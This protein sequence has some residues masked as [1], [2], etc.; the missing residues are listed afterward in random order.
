MACYCF[1][2]GY[3]WADD[4]R[5]KQSA[6]YAAL[7]GSK[8]KAPVPLA[9]YLVETG[10]GRLLTVCQWPEELMPDIERKGGVWGK[11]SVFRKWATEA[12]TEV[13]QDADIL[14]PR[15]EGVET[16]AGGAR[17]LSSFRTAEQAATTVTPVGREAIPS[18]PS[19]ERYLICY[20]CQERN[21]PDR[22]ACAKCGADLL[23]AR[24][25]VERIG[26]LVGGAI[27]AAGF[28]GLAYALSHVEDPL[29]CASPPTLLVMALAALVGGLRMGFGKTPEYEKYE[30]RAQRQLND[31]PQQALADLTKALELAPEK[32]KAGILKQRGDLY[33][34]L[35]RKEEALADLSA[36][37]ASPHAHKGA[38]VLSEVVGVDLEPTAA[39]GTEQA[40]ARLQT[41]L[42]QEGALR[43]IGYCKRCKDAVELDAERRCSRCGGKIKEPQFVKRDEYEAG[44][45]KVRAD[46]AAR[47]RKRVIWLTVGGVAILAC[48]LCIGGTILSEGWESLLPRTGTPTAAAP[49]TTFSDGGFSFEYPSSWE[50]IGEGEVEDLLDSSLKGL[51]P[52]SCDY[53]GGVYYDDVG[54]RRGCAEIVVVAVR[55][56]AFSGTLTDEQYETAREA[57]GAQMGSRLVSH[58]KIEVSSMPGVESVHLGAS[59]RTKI[60]DLIVIPPEP[61]LAYMISCSTH[62]DSYDEFEPVFEHAVE[63]LRIGESAPPQPGGTVAPSDCTLDAIYVAD[64]TIPDNTHIEA[65][66]P[67]VK[68]WRIRNAGTCAWGPGY[69][70]TFVEGDHMGGADWVEVPAAGPGEAA[71]ISV[72][73]VAPAL[74]GQYRGYWRMC[75][76]AEQCFGDRVY[77]QIVSEQE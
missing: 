15:P 76:S 30:K 29:C 51:D 55:D 26:W 54:S 13:Y 38:S 68:T 53:I 5:A 74:P 47:R 18:A 37:S 4:E 50:V 46:V 73:L 32:Q 72:E 56:A 21:E 11:T 6:L 17:T 70:L 69:R 77:L 9:V 25:L 63:T 41:D 67:F 39:L 61:G 16:I 19:A 64:I 1:V 8:D 36:Y 57:A 66:Q 48:A 65:G 59:G 23:P 45:E 52:A 3:P 71:D 14:G 28:V 60:W 75:V 27:L 43:A 40:V 44:L 62:E 58:R 7:E 33:S 31:V 22:K 24:V 49:P 20:K 2:M 42:V 35:G 10:S 12:G 34:K